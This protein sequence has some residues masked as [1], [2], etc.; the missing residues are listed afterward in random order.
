MNDASADIG[1]SGAPH[2]M[3]IWTIPGVTPERRERNCYPK[4][5][6]GRNQPKSGLTSPQLHGKTAR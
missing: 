3:P 6:D 1:T 2:L 5:D 4:C